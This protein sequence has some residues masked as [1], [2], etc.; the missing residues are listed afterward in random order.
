M[1]HRLRLLAALTVVAVA[2]AAW[3]DDVPAGFK[4][5]TPELK[6]AGALAFGPDGILFV[7]DAPAGTIYAIATGDT[8][9]AGTKS[10]KVEK[11]DDAIGGLLGIPGTDVVVNDLKVNPASGTVYISGARGR[12]P[13][14][15]AVLVKVGADGKPTEVPLKDVKY[16]SIKLDNTGNK[17][18]PAITSMAFHKG[19]LYVAGL[20][21]E[22]WQSN[23][24]AIPFPFSETTTKGAGVQIYHGAHGK[25]ETQSPVQ[26]FM[27][28]EIN[29][30]PNLVASYICTPLVKFPVEKVKGGDKVKGTTVAELGSGN[31]PLDIIAYEK[32]DKHYALMAN[33]RHGVIK[34]HLDGID[35]IAEITA[36]VPRGETAGLKYDKV[37]GQAGVIQLDKLNAGTAVVLKKTGT[38]LALETVALP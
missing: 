14:A 21:N 22:E 28:Y 9:P 16:S 10:L 3:A 13:G 36:P 1:T 24:K 32:D 23:L 30:Q 19:D 37:T 4:S 33:D 8:K 6:A 15:A 29:G 35:K 2:P 27:A 20:T 11:L 7:A 18:S 12:A 38:N 5:G 17:R 26:T 25:Y 31:R 34:V